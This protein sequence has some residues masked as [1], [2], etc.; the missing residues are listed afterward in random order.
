MLDSGRVAGLRKALEAYRHGTILDVG[1]GLGECSR[2]AE[3]GYTGIDNSSPRIA[4]AAK[5]YPQHTFL[6]GDARSLPFKAATFDLAMLI[7]TSHH[8]SD[9]QLRTV[10]V[11]MKRVARK[12]LVISDPVPFEGQGSVSALF[13]RL[14]RGAC[15]RS[16]PQM[17]EFLKTFE[18]TELVNVTPF[19]TFPGIYVH[20]AFV[21]KKKE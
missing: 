15:F 18:G 19:R 8:L 1:C 16:I 2:F 13:Y 21:L 14:D 3:A 6:V 17:Q 20:A 4:F 10:L 12:Y 7:D 9:D 11:E 5:R